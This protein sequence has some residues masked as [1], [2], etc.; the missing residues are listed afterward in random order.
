[1]QEQQEERSP[2]TLFSLLIPI[3]TNQRRSTGR[4]Q[5]PP[6]TQFHVHYSKITIKDPVTFRRP[7]SR[8]YVR[9]ADVDSAGS[10][11]LFTQRM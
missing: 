4:C 9:Y 8:A 10:S 5:S 7:D 6:W 3:Y 11:A 1:M 2:G